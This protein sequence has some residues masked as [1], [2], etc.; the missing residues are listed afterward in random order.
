MLLNNAIYLTT[1]SLCCTADHAIQFFFNWLYMD[2][3]VNSWMSMCYYK[4]LKLVPTWW[5]VKEFVVYIVRSI[6]STM[7]C[8]HYLVFSLYM[9]SGVSQSITPTGLSAAT[10]V[11]SSHWSKNKWPSWE[12]TLSMLWMKENIPQASCRSDKP[13]DMDGGRVG[14]ILTLFDILF[15][16]LTVALYSFLR[17]HYCFFFAVLDFA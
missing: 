15:L 4:H 17:L 12:L 11:V 6:F 8:S 2:L 10:K 13:F 3:K 1:T 7:E 9:S 5:L 14:P 16:S